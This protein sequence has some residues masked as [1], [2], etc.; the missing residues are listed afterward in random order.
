MSAL[1]LLHPAMTGLEANAWMERHRAELVVHHRQG[2]LHLLVTAQLRP[3]P[4][5]PPPFS[6]SGCGWAGAEPGLIPGPTERVPVCPKC[7]AVHPILL[8]SPA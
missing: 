7:D 4:T 6:C 8:R 2:K 5:S 1:V 3:A